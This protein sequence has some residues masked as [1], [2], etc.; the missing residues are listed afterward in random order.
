MI[1]SGWVR[2]LRTEDDELLGYIVPEA[3]GRVTPVTVFGLALAPPGP[4]DEAERRLDEVG[5]SYLADRWLLDVDGREEPVN[6]E[7]VE[8]GPHTVTVKCV[9]FGYEQNYG[10]LFTLAVPVDGRLRR[11]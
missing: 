5:L 4:R 10:T 6:V 2:Y 7:I 8:A 3:E 1:P 9:D 11:R